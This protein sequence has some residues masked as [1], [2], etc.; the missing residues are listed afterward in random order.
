MTEMRSLPLSKRPDTSRLNFDL[1]MMLSFCLKRLMLGPERG[2][3]EGATFAVFSSCA[4]IYG[5]NGTERNRAANS[6]IHLR[7]KCLV[8]L[9]LELQ[10]IECALTYDVNNF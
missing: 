6:V 4:C 2:R 10:H 7:E 9:S 8:C 5:R 1:F 3:D